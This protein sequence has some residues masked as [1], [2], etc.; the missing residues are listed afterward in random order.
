MLMLLFADFIGLTAGRHR[1]GC[2]SS[3]AEGEFVYT[4]C[5]NPKQFSVGVSVDVPLVPFLSPYWL[6]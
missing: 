5:K 3:R 4:L 6:G 2:D 1:K